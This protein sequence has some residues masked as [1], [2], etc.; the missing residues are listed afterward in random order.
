MGDR[1]S[2]ASLR[3][4]RSLFREQG[5]V[6]VPGSSLLAV[7]G[8]SGTFA[9]FR[10]TWSELPVDPYFL[11]PK[12]NRFRRHAQMDLNAGSGNLEWRPNS[13]YF[14]SPEHNSIFGGITRYFAPIERTGKIESVLASLIRLAAEEMFGLAGSWVV[15]VH[16]VRIISDPDSS[17]SPAPEGP[18]HDGYEFISLHLMDRNNDSGGETMILDEVTAQLH[19][20]TLDAPLDTLYMDDRRFRHHVTPISAPGRECHRDMILMSYERPEDAKAAR[21]QLTRRQCLRSSTYM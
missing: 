3:N 10:R 20:L 5:F 1:S 18:H 6:F 17:A 21:S 15:N 12:P 8:M 13:G 7:D 4:E 16:F 14:Q 9:D 11:G 2:K 19:T